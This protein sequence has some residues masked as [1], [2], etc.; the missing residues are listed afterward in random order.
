[1]FESMIADFQSRH[2]ISL[3]AVAELGDLREQ[4]ALRNDSALET[5]H[6]APARLE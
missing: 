1:M 4:T 6:N 3:A 2:D 5:V